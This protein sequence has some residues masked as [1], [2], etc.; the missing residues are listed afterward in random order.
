MSINGPVTARYAALLFVLIGLLTINGFYLL[1]I[2][3][4]EWSLGLFLQNPGYQLM[5]AVHLVAGMLMLLV[6]GLYLA[7]HLPVV[8]SHANAGARREGLRLV[9]SLVVVITTGLLLTRGISDFE[10]SRPDVRWGLYLGHVLAPIAGFWFFYQHRPQVIKQ[11]WT[12]R[13]AL[14]GSVMLAVAFAPLL[15]AFDPPPSAPGNFTGTSGGDGFPSLIKTQTGAGIPAEALMND[16]YCL[17]CHAE[18]HNQWAAS[19]HRFSSFNNPFYRVSL[20]ETRAHLMER[21]GNTHAS[22]FCA[23]CH[24]VVPLLS[25]EFDHPDFDLESSPSASAGLTCT[26]CHAVSSVDSPRGNSDFTIAAPQHYPFARSESPSL[27]WVSNVL[28]KANPDF[29]K[30]TF[31]KPLHKSAEFCATCH[32]VH[33]PQ[34]LNQYRWLRGQNHY[35]S[36]LLSGVSG[37]RVDSFY[38]PK[39]PQPNCNGCHMP[40]M[41]STEFGATL[42]STFSGTALNNHLFVGANTALSQF[43]DDPLTTLRAHQKFLKDSVT[44]DV[45]GV[46]GGDDSIQTFTGPLSADA[47][48][49]IE[50]PITRE[51]LVEV[52][53]RTR[54]LGHLFTQGTSDSNQVWLALEVT[55]TDGQ[56]LAQNGVMDPKTRQVPE[57]AHRVNVYMLDRYGN[58][59][60][61]RN[62][63]DIYTPLFNNQIPPGTAA[64]VRYRFNVPEGVSRA[65]IKATLNYRKFDT[66]YVQFTEGAEVLNELPVTEIAS[67]ITHLNFTHATPQASLQ[68]ADWQ[69]LNDYGI[70]LLRSG[71]GSQLRQAER[72]FEAVAGLGRTEGTLN[73]IR[74]YYTE[75]RLDEAAALLKTYTPGPDDA[76][77]TAQWYSALVNLD[78]GFL[79]EGISQL[80]ELV[81]DPDG[82]L[83]KRGLDLSRDYN[84][85]NRL[86]RALITLSGAHASDQHRYRA[87]L[88]RAQGYYEQVLILDPEN[89]AAHYGLS[90]IYASLGDSVRSQEHQALHRRYKPDDNA[91]QMVTAKA[92]RSPVLDELA[93]RVTVYPLKAMGTKP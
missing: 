26:V 88:E 31:L 41:P 51:L 86:A 76:W 8:R 18:T 49:S 23:G 44:V 72:A 3:F 65:N 12:R 25:G 82:I 91:Q 59:I 2:S 52:V 39:Q 32:K 93:K 45:I 47:L 22:R 77:W 6:L 70:A 10:I 16:S 11:L 30:R 35:D 13:S 56:L 67:A 58:R 73:L 29:H 89:V 19:A 90:Q 63:Q 54:T 92:R 87:T 55:D 27:R 69:R 74:L 71:G 83:D 66:Q 38:Y 80:V 68:A 84:L 24:D 7:G 1:V 14:L 40:E 61:R 28:L 60:A 4:I 46:R 53:L 42:A 85:L 50:L 57:D 48:N 37:H 9:W 33:I 34:E 5:F 64:L 75:G 79:E 62:V 81:G 21:D 15:V 36:F 78:T 20:L 43:T 17:T